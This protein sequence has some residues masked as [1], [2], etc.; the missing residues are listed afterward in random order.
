MTDKLAEQALGHLRQCLLPRPAQD[1]IDLEVPSWVVRKAVTA[2]EATAALEQRLEGLEKLEEIEQ[3]CIRLY[4][5]EIT[6]T[7]WRRVV[8]NGPL[9]QKLVALAEKA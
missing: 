5:G 2:L 4:V 3:A 6:K 1:G 7:E 8:R 9:A